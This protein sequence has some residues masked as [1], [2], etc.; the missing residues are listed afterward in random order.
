FSPTADGRR[1]PELAAPGCLTIS[2][3]SSTTCG[4]TSSGFT[5]TSMACPAVSG[6]GLLVRQYYTD[7]FYPSGVANVSDGFIPSGALIKATLINSA[8]DMS[9]VAGFPSAREGWG[10]VLL[11]NALYFKDDSRKL[12]VLHDRRNASGLTTGQSQNYDFTCTSGS[13]S[14]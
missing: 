11:E 5:G 13:Q 4:F 6:A 3:Q 12:V 8:V 10:R 9:G 14:V 1:K 7:G 2:A